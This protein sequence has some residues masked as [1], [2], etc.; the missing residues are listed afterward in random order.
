MAPH[1]F[2]KDVAELLTPRPT[3]RKEILDRIR[4]LVAIQNETCTHPQELAKAMRNE[5]LMG[6]NESIRG[7]NNL[8]ALTSTGAGARR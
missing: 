7:I 4:E 1:E 6:W 3:M 8:T 5:E 2:E